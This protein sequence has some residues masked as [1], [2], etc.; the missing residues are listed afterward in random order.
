MCDPRIAMNAATRTI[1]A[2]FAGSD[3]W[4]EIGPTTNQ[5]CAPAMISPNLRTRASRISPAAYI[6]NESIRNIR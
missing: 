5:R 1:V 6:G 4:N 2:S 3:G